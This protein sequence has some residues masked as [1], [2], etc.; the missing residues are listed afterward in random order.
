[1]VK[2]AQVA[3]E[4]IGEQRIKLLTGSNCSSTE[5]SSRQKS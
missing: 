3:E 2:S 1:M 4:L 5:R